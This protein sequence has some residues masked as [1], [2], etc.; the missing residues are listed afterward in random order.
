[1]GLLIGDSQKTQL[2]F[3]SLSGGGAREFRLEL[4]PPRL[5]AWLSVTSRGPVQLD[6]HDSSIE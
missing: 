5:V 1:M 2:L 3:P 4:G 6:G